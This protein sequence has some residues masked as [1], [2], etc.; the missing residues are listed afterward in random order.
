MR[1][2]LTQIENHMFFLKIVKIPDCLPLNVL[3]MP[4][5]AEK[6]AEYSAPV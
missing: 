4:L 2:T 3:V 6:I 5:S 1:P